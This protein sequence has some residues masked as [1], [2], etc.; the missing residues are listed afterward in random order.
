MAILNR[1]FDRSPSEDVSTT[2]GN[3]LISGVENTGSKKLYQNMLMDLLHAK[4]LSF[5]LTVHYLTRIIK[6]I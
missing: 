1:I 5:L 3:M 6:R 4:K 2:L